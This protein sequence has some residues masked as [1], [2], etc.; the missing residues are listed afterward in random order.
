MSRFE[1]GDSVIIKGF[2]DDVYEVH[3]VNMDGTLDLAPEK[4]PVLQYIPERYLEPAPEP[5]HKVY[6][7]DV[8]QGEITGT[9][10][11]IVG[12][13]EDRSNYVYVF[14]SRTHQVSK[15]HV[16]QFQRR[17]SLELVYSG[18]NVPQGC[19]W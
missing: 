9:L 4:G 7:G 2:E 1:E 17:E 19:S 12:T 13:V 18:E 6:V 5:K 15:E 11:R 16:G 14:D 8:Y 3:Y 10:Y